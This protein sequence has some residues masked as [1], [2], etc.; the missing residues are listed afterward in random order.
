MDA[1]TVSTILIVAF[2]AA[3]GYALWRWYKEKKS[4]PTNTGQNAG[5]PSNNKPE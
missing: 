5:T 4:T 3:L 1:S 2:V